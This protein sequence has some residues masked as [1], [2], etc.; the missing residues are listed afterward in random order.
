MNEIGGAEMPLSMY[1]EF[2][3]TDTIKEE[4]GYYKFI[5]NNLANCDTA[6]FMKNAYQLRELVER[7]DKATG[8]NNIRAEKLTVE[9]TA[10]DEVK[11]VAEKNFIKDKW[12]RILGA[13]FGNNYEITAELLAAFCFATVDEIKE[14]EPYE[15]NNLLFVLL[16]NARI[17]DFFTSLRLWGLIDTDEL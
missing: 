9:D 17:K 1:E 3:M 2:I 13:C 16:S 10:S 11:T 15:L 8:I 14:L 7:F 5:G 4:K 6:T 12:S